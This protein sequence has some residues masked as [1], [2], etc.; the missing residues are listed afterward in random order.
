MTHFFLKIISPFNSSGYS[1]SV[2]TG[3]ERF[4]LDIPICPVTCRLGVQCKVELASPVCDAG[5]VGT[6]SDSDKSLFSR[7]NFFLAK[8]ARKVFMSQI[9]LPLF[10]DFSLGLFSLVILAGLVSNV[11]LFSGNEGV[12]VRVGTGGTG[13]GFFGGWSFNF[14]SAM[15]GWGLYS[16]LRV[17]VEVSSGVGVFGGTGSILGLVEAGFNLGLANIDFGW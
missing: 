2:C 3:S 7:S 9:S 5:G 14:G 13:L 12:V 1:P 11:G 16:G 8:N 17:V 10:T 6:R 4:G 15:V